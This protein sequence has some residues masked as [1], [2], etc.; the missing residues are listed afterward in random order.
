MA[1]SRQMRSSTATSLTVPPSE[2]VQ[3]T[4]SNDEMPY[5]HHSLGNE[6]WQEPTP[7][8]P[9]PSFEDY[10]GLERQGVLEHM[11]PLG[12]F[13]SSKVKAR[14]KHYEPPRRTTH[15]RN[16]EPKF[17]SEEIATTEPPSLPI[18]T[19]DPSLYHTGPSFEM[20]PQPPY[21]EHHLGFTSGPHDDLPPTQHFPADPQT[22]ILHTLPTQAVTPM[23]TVSS[24]LPAAPAPPTPRMQTIGLHDIVQK[25]IDRFSQEGR[26]FLG[27]ALQKLYNE[28]QYDQSQLHL[29][30]AILSNNHS[31]EQGARFQTFIKAA[32]RQAKKGQRS[33]NAS[34]SALP[35]PQQ[36]RGSQVVATR[37]TAPSGIGSETESSSHNFQNPFPASPFET[38]SKT[39]KSSTRRQM[40]NGTASKRE[41]R[42]NK[43]KRS[44]SASSDSSLSSFTADIE[45]L[46]PDN[47]SGTRTRSSASQTSNLRGGSHSR[48]GKTSKMGHIP[49]DDNT[50]E[51]RVAARKRIGYGLNNVQVTESAVRTSVSPRRTQ[52]TSLTTNHQRSQQ[53]RSNGATP[54]LI[55]DQDDSDSPLSSHD[56]LPPPPS[57]A[58]R[59]VTPQLGRPPK[60]SKKAVRIKQS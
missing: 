55:A 58:G 48:R 10:K 3:S 27:I 44:G 22:H 24:A 51:T 28:A 12:S 21:S 16:G 31:Q 43:R 1:S 41:S 9:A 56:E 26:G 60:A 54:R 39:S 7:R 33:T 42:S 45:A 25:A 4:Y 2:H 23:T 20:P 19:V 11:A 30:N 14:I 18:S 37:Q 32:R 52:N 53:P 13:P 34:S 5:G 38:P 40:E 57:Y 17:V 36:E 59:G 8:A 50:V 49:T 47:L 46:R 29:L 35:T 15:L 6:E